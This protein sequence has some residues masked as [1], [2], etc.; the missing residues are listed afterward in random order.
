MLNRTEMSWNDFVDKLAHL[1]KV[2]LI[3]NLKYDA[4]DVK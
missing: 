4:Q 1:E 2:K 3:I